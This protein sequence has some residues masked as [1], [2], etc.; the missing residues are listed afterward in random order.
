MSSD[1]VIKARKTALSVTGGIAA[2]LAALL[3]AALATG[4]LVLVSRIR[5]LWVVLAIAAPLVLL[6][7]RWTV[8]EDSGKRHWTW[9][10]VAYV[11]VLGAL[12]WVYFV[13]NDTYERKIGPWP[14]KPQFTPD[15]I[16]FGVSLA[17]VIGLILIFALPTLVGRLATRAPASGLGGISG[18]LLV[19]ALVSGCL[20]LFSEMDYVASIKVPDCF[21]DASNQVAMSNQTGESDQK[22]ESDQVNRS[23]KLRPLNQVGAA[24]FAVTTFS[25]V[26]LGDIQPRGDFCRPLVASQIVLGFIIVTVIVAVA[27][28]RPANPPSPANPTPAN[29]ANL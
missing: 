22:D 15:W 24:Y 25:T 11:I 29:P 21:I 2:V 20:A 9:A 13:L 8:R 14:L 28:S 7:L 5:P 1:R 10:G 16:D 26:G 17:S 18:V 3:V 6:A 23:N 4:V 12:P 19:I 27:L